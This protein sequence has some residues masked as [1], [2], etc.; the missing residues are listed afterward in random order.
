MEGIHDLRD[1]LKPRDWMAK[2]DLKDAYFML[3]IHEKDRAFLKFSLNNQTYQFRCLPSGLA[4][5]H[6]DP[7]ASSCPA[8][9]TAEECELSFT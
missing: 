6:Q 9:T 7:Q 8:E 4:C 5:L 2:V 3:P 1:L